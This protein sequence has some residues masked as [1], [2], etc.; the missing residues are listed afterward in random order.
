MEAYTPDLANLLLPFCRDPFKDDQ[1]PGLSSKSVVS[2]G[3]F[4]D[5][6]R[7]AAGA[8][9]VVKV[10]YTNRSQDD[11]RLDFTARDFGA[12]TQVKSF[13]LALVPG[14]NKVATI[15]FAAASKSQSAVGWVDVRWQG[16]DRSRP[17]I[18]GGISIPVFYFVGPNPL[19]EKSRDRG[20]LTLATLPSTLR[21]R[22]NLKESVSLRCFGRKQRGREDGVGQGLG[23]GSGFSSSLLSSSL[24]VGGEGPSDPFPFSSS[25]NSLSDSV[26]SFGLPLGELGIDED[27]HS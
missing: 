23:L 21:T 18:S 3:A 14:L 16:A 9:C 20:S 12:E 22:F 17:G 19:D 7:V 1:G 15:S 27:F 11:L 25:C 10:K 24:S 13:T 26:A 8:D 4:L 2:N 6:G 5:L